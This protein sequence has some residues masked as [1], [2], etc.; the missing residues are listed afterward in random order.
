MEDKK[1]RKILEHYAGYGLE[2]LLRDYLRISQHAKKPLIGKIIQKV[3]ASTLESTHAGQV[4]TL[5][6]AL[7]IVDLADNHIILPCYCKKL[8]KGE[9]SFNC[10]NFGPI[11]EFELKATPFKEFKEVDT[12]EIKYMLK[13]MNEKGFFQQVISA[14]MPF[15]VSLCNCD[16]TY[17][18]A[19]KSR[20]AH[21]LDSGLLKGHEIA[22]VD[23]NEC[24]LCGEDP[25][26][27]PRCQFGAIKVNRDGNHVVIDPSL[28]FGCGICVSV[29]QNKA[30]SLK[31]RDLNQY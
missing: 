20:F 1:R 6:D 18:V 17:C 8:I 22:I 13:D 31:K 2:Y 28:C 10:I 27:I 12:A 29:C 9:D 3:M 7:K 16:K 15:P 4:I 25:Q 11:K 14:K 5:E 24:D 30:I 21:G 19:A 26:C 23:V